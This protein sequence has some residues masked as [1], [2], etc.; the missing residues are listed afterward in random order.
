MTQSVQKPDTKTSFI[1]AVGGGMLFSS[2]GVQNQA[3]ALGL[4]PAG[5][6]PV[7]VFPPTPDQSVEAFSVIFSESLTANR[8]GKRSDRTGKFY[9]PRGKSFVVYSNVSQLI[10][11][12]HMISEI[13]LHNIFYFRRWLVVS[14]RDVCV[15]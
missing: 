9:K 7:A 13:I 4:I 8:R 1:L 3:L 6:A 11:L 5:T 14:R 15:L 10:K 2:A 12:Y